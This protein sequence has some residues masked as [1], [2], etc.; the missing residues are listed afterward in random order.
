MEQKICRLSESA[1]NTLLNIARNDPSPWQNPE[2]DF[3]GIL[4]QQGIP[5]YTEEVKGIQVAGEIG[6]KILN[7]DKAPQHNDTQGLDFHSAL[8]GLSPA[9]AADP[10]LWA[11]FTH[12]RHHSYGIERWPLGKKRKWSFNHVKSH[13]FA[14]SSSLNALA[15][16]N[17][18]A[19]TWWM[20]EWA[21]R[22]VKHSVHSATDILQQLAS[23]NTH[24][25]Y[26]TIMGGSGFLYNPYVAA[27][28]HDTIADNLDALNFRGVRAVMNRL[29][30]RTGLY[31]LD[32]L[33]HN[34]LREYIQGSIES[35][36][37][38]PEYTRSR[39]PKY[40]APALRVLS[41]GAGVQSSVL[42]LM[43]ER[44]E[45]GLPKPD[46]AIFADTGWEPQAVYD[47]LAWLQ[48]KLSFPVYRVSAGNIR[49]DLLNGT[50]PDGDNFISI[51]VYF[52]GLD[53]KNAGMSYR[54]CTKHYK[55]NPINQHIR[56]I[57]GIPDGRP[58]PK[59]KRVEQWLG[60][61]I[62]ESQRQKPSRYSWISLRYPLVELGFSRY[63]LQDWFARHYGHRD[64]PK[65]SCIGCP[66]RSDDSWQHMKDNDR[67]AW[68]DAVEVDIALRS[69]PERFPKMKHVPFLHSTRMP[70]EEVGFSSRPDQFGEECDGLCGI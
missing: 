22:L 19:R 23:H 57:L 32:A 63:Q 70:L 12:F 38:N 67:A 4:V 9:Q 28:Y 45:H 41:L 5:D 20:A 69:D 6:L 61:S 24:W 42:A 50:K 17:T 40:Q 11:W 55:I 29:Q 25:D 21:L 56:K 43:A 2:T 33:D 34:D 7:P 49:Q 3:A 64:L 51:P 68:Q 47:H 46:F 39:Q 66:Y 36:L 27:V 58:V 14:K 54:Q 62:D 30:H 48:S 60:I 31:L 10:R 65:S 15:Q 52:K 53:G 18:S 44:G 26:L 1:Y 37:S 59:T 13:W 16:S 8:Q 35:V